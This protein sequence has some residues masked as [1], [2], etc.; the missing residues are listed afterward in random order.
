MPTK[1]VYKILIPEDVLNK[2]KE[3]YHTFQRDGRTVLVPIG[4]AV[5][6]PEWV[7]IRAK[8]IGLIEDY[9]VM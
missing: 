6:V 8:E 2:G 7:A 4:K 3:Q 1:K 9:F 5:Q